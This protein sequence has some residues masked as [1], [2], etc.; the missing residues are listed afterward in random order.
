MNLRKP[1][2]EYKLVLWHLL[3]PSADELT[4]LCYSHDKTFLFIVVALRA[5]LYAN[6]FKLLYDYKI[7]SFKHDNNRR[8]LFVMCSTILIINIVALIN[9]IFKRQ[10]HIKLVLEDEEKP[11]ALDHQ[12]MKI[13]KRVDATLAELELQE[14][15]KERNTILQ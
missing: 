4:T 3:T 8:F 14:Q 12:A 13:P 6:I 1:C 5:V 11:I 9:A 10:R 2:K 7:I 15:L